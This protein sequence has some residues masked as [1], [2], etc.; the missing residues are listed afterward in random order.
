MKRLL[1]V[2]ALLLSVGVASRV[3]GKAVGPLALCQGLGCTTTQ[4]C[5]AACGGPG[6]AV[7]VNHRCV[8]L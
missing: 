6:N 2:L 4:Q 8:L 3:P 1:W 7:C 5:S